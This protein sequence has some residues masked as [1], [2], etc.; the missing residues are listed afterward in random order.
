MMNMLLILWKFW[1]NVIFCKGVDSQFHIK[2]QSKS[3]YLTNDQVAKICRT[4]FGEVQ[5]QTM[6]A[7]DR[8]CIYQLF[9]GFL[10]DRLAGILDQLFSF[11]ILAF[12]KMLF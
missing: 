10:H 7:V 11:Y 1:S 6:V 12:L 5:T 8:L 2:F 9:S 3:S 4:I